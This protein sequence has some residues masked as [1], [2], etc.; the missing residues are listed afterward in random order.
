MRLN[1]V[2]PCALTLLTALCSPVA[3]HGA[4]PTITEF[5]AG[6]GPWS[7]ARGDDGNV[8]FA[9]NPR[10]AA[11]GSITPGGAAA[12]YGGLAP[13]S[14][15]TDIASGPG[16]LWFTENATNRIGRM[17]TGGVLSEFSAGAH[18]KPTG[19]TAGPDGN[20]WY[21]TTGKGGAIGRITPAGTVTEFTTGLTTNS[22]PQDIALG[23]DGNLW[24]TEAA[25]NRIGRITPQGAITEFTTG[26]LFGAPQEIAAGPD[27][28]LWFT[29]QGLLPA[30]GRI[31]TNGATTT[32]RTGLAS[33]SRPQGIT[34]GADGN[35]YFTDNGADAIGRVTPAGNITAFSAGLTVGAGLEGIATGGDGRLWFAETATA[36]VGRMTVAPAAG[37]VAASAVADVTATVSG[38]VTPNSEATTYHFEWGTTAAYGQQTADVGAG[39]G[40]G[41]Q[42]VTQGLTGLMPTTTYHVRLVATSNAGVTLGIEQTFT[43][44]PAAPGAPTQDADAFSPSAP[45]ASSVPARPVAEPAAAASIPAVAPRP[46]PELG[47]SAVAKVARGTI[48]FRAPGSATAIELSGETSLPAGSVIDARNGTL[49]LENALDGSGRTQQATFRGAQFTFSLSR[50]EPGMMDVRLAQAPPSCPARGAGTVRA[51]KGREPVRRLWIKDKKG[52]YRTHGRNSVAI[53]RGTE[54]TTAETCAGTVTRVIKGAV[55]VRNVRTGRSV[56][57]RAGRTYIARRSR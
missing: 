19:I 30:I 38:D 17:T 47:R 52:K 23:P 46:R 44:A 14:R 32:F 13:D 16:G 20:V 33:G 26:L 39:S 1:R 4:T 41:A 2:L 9:D 31:T 36:K 55:L 54:W 12:T 40:A 6:A 57:L 48:R 25:S 34:A 51:A 7:L 35:V 37:A 56:L 27:G 5:P 50:R 42:A 10:P 15:P 53:V 29:D 11:I 49:V 43:T 45:T 8:W 24:F 18:D 28:K 21:T 22:S 3:A